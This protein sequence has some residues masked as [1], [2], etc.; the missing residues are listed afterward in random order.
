MVLTGIMSVKFLT[1]AITGS[2]S[3]DSKALVIDFLS[4]NS[5]T[6][7]ATIVASSEAGNKAVIALSPYLTN[8]A[9]TS[10]R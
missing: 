3:L 2:A 9:L 5:Q 10:G 1:S 7:T 4:S 8:C 6:Q